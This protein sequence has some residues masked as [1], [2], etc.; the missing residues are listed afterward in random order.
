MPAATCIF[1]SHQWGCVNGMTAIDK[2][3]PI[4][5][6]TLHAGSTAATA[7]CPSL[8]AI[9]KMVVIATVDNDKRNF[10]NLFI[11]TAFP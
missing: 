11:R 2:S 5:G 3:I 8:A 4:K 9:G 10:K 7:S 1:F 6:I